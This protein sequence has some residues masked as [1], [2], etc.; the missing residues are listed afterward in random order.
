MDLGVKYPDWELS[1]EIGCWHCMLALDID[2]GCGH[3]A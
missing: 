2:I 1:V 3:L